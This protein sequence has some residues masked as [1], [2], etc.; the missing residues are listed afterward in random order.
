[1]KDDYDEVRS[2]SRQRLI[3]LE[4]QKK[5]IIDDKEQ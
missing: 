5:K 3:E 4:E 2:H 1:M